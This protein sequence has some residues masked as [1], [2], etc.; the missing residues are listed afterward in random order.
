MRV[1]NPWGHG[2]WMLDWSDNPLN[3][4]PDYM[5]LS[6]YQ[7]DLDKFYENKIARAKQNG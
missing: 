2:E 1:R 6:K 5:K 4:D 3:K 7:K